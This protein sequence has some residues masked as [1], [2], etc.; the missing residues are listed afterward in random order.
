MPCDELLYFLESLP[1]LD[2]VNLSWQLLWL[3]MDYGLLLM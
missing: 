3:Q 1:Y 2:A